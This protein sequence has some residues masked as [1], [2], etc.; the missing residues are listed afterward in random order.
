MRTIV[1]RRTYSQSVRNQFKHGKQTGM[2]ALMMAVLALGGAAQAADPFQ[3]ET[4]RLASP[5]AGKANATKPWVDY[6][7]DWP[8]N[9]ANPNALRAMQKTIL[10]DALN[11][12]SE[13]LSI[14]GNLSVLQYIFMEEIA[15]LG[16][17]HPDSQW[18]HSY[19]SISAR[20]SFQNE[21]FVLYTV[22]SEDYMGGAHGNHATRHLIF[23]AQTG[24]ALGVAELFK[25]GTTSELSRRIEARIQKVRGFHSA[26]EMQ[27]DFLQVKRVEPQ[28]VF[29]S[30]GRI[31]FRYNHN[32]IACYAAG[33][34]DVEFDIAELADLLRDGIREA[35]SG[36]VPS[37]R[38]DA[39]SCAGRQAQ[40]NIFEH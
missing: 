8:T 4:I 38:R 3:T 26:E 12:R 33:E 22:K 19:E 9:A 1:T 16:R 23:D 2:V 34:T 32:D 35:L 20:V 37:P 40:Q 29:L 36:R 5:E 13:I 10:K 15:E 24:K 30:A 14:R 25:A 27:K 18:T 21:R 17:E 31:G 28:N 39:V 7:V 11:A 6:S